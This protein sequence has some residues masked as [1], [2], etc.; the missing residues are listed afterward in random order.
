MLTCPPIDGIKLETIPIARKAKEHAYECF[1]AI[2]VTNVEIVNHRC[3][4]NTQQISITLGSILDKIQVMNNFRKYPITFEIQEVEQP[5]LSQSEK[6][7]M[8][9]CK[10]TLGI[11][12]YTS[13]ILTLSELG[14]YLLQTKLIT[15]G[16]M[17]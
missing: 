12:K 16:V 6:F 17:Y 15:L 8:K 7:Y 13:N 9:Y 14:R 10:Q 2:Q 5:K 11:S 1:N 4:H 3:L